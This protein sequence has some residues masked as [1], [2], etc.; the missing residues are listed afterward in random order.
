MQN[1]KFRESHI[2]QSQCLDFKKLSSMLQSFLKKYIS[3][4]NIDNPLI[5]GLGMDVWTSVTP[6]PLA[7]PSPSNILL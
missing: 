4:S 6:T 7:C 1:P 2:L 3:P 5:P